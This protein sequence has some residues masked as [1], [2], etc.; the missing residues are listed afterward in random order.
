MNDT[1]NT[2][3]TLTI[4]GSLNQNEI[5]MHKNITHIQNAYWN[6]E[7]IHKMTCQVIICTRRSKAG[8]NFK[9][10]KEDNISKQR[11]GMK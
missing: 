5:I 3:L 8:G 2:S 11:D 1:E 7:L 6:K 4:V 10:D 9:I